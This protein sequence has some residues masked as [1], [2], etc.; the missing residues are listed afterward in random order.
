MACYAMETEY[1]SGVRFIPVRL[2]DGVQWLQTL[3]VARTAAEALHGAQISDAHE[4]GPE[5]AADNELIGVAE[6]DLRIMA[7]HLVPA[8]APAGGAR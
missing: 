1:E 6:V 2:T 5:W 8:V 4:L 3:Y 7:L